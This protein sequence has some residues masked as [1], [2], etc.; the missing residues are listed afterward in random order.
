MPSLTK[1]TEAELLTQ[2]IEFISQT[3]TNCGYPVCS[4]Q[5][6]HAEPRKIQCCDCDGANKGYTIYGWIIDA[7]EADGRLLPASS[8]DCPTLDALRLGFTVARC[9]P[10]MKTMPKVGGA[11]DAAAVEL[12]MVL[13]CLRIV[14]NGCANRPAM[15]HVEPTE[16][17]P[18]PP[19]QLC[20]KMIVG[21]FTAETAESVTVTPI[22]DGATVTTTCAGWRFTLTVA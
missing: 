22:P 1:L 12:A 7:Y 2:A 17:E 13:D 15:F 9:W 18:D 11:Q 6:T 16:E 21:A 14:L 4:V 3:L 20:T 19:R 5:R 8:L 10:Q